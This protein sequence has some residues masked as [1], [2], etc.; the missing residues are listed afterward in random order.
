MWKTIPETNGLYAANELGEIKRV[1]SGRIVSSNLSGGNRGRTYKYVHLKVNGK[2]K[3]VLLH[4]IVANLF[5]PNPAGK[6]EVDH[7]D[8]N[9]MNCAASNLRWATRSE[10]LKNKDYS[11]HPTPFMRK[12]KPKAVEITK[13][14]T[15][16]TMTFESISAAARYMG[17]KRST[18]ASNII[19]VCKGEYSQTHGYKCSYVL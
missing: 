6:P 16:E 19:R 13:I 18:T 9:P 2:Y 17:G 14:S 11:K 5:V 3:N 4:R 8:G 12:D 1:D 7:V 10:N 15:G